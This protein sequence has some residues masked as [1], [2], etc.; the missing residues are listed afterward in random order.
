MAQR[1]CLPI[2]GYSLQLFK[3]SHVKEF[4]HALFQQNVFDTF[5]VTEGSITTFVTYKIDGQYHREFFEHSGEEDFSD[6][7]ASM[8]ASDA[9][10]EHTSHSPAQPAYVTWKQVKQIVMSMIRGERTPLKMN[11]VFRLADYNVEKLLKQA[12]LSLQPADIAG[13]YLNI[14]FEDRHLT[15]TTGSSLRIFTL[16][17]SLDHTWDDMVRRLL[18]SKDIEFETL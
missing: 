4:M 15:I 9:P 16:D 6:G 3:I 5:L 13:L 1:Y 17:K 10:S 2:G 18:I 8:P 7:N 11:F 14:L 12:D